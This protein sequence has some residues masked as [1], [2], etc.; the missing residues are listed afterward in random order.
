MKP[1]LEVWR[2]CFILELNGVLFRN[3]TASQTLTGLF[4]VDTGAHLFTFSYFN[5]KKGWSKSQISLKR[6][7]GRLNHLMN[8]NIPNENQATLWK[9]SFQ[10][11]CM[12]VKHKITLN[13]TERATSIQGCNFNKFLGV[14]D[15]ARWIFFVCDLCFSY[16]SSPMVLGP[17]NFPAEVLCTTVFALRKGKFSRLEGDSP[18]CPLKSRPCI[19]IC[20]WLQALILG[21]FCK[22]TYYFRSYPQAFSKDMA[23]VGSL[24]AMQHKRCTQVSGVFNILVKLVWYT[25]FTTN[26]SKIS[27]WIVWRLSN[28][29]LHQ[30]LLRVAFGMFYSKVSLFGP[31]LWS[32]RA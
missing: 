13:H 19:H 16:I 1:I 25:C 3:I 31:K 2:L 23:K 5:S 28:H 15:V 30:A 9:H 29:L 17:V 22:M 20:T 14:S 12:T 8:I 18:P 21:N 27:S 7:L 11:F 24:A 6:K 32:F 10:H 4:T 26:S